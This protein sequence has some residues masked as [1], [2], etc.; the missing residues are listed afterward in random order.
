MPIQPPCDDSLQIQFDRTYITAQEIS[1]GIGITPPA[2][3]HAIRREK[4]PAP[5]VRIPGCRVW[6]WLRDETFEPI[7]SWHHKRQTRNIKKL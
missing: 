6:L 4:F 5:V 1:L 3:Y 2:L 7:N